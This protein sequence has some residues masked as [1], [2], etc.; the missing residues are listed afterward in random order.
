MEGVYTQLELPGRPSL[1]ERGLYY[2]YSWLASCLASW[3]MVCTM[4]CIMVYTYG[5][6]SMGAYFFFSSK[7]CNG[8]SYRH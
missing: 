5:D 8:R 7:H 3:Y 2:S 6:I 1:L 4:V